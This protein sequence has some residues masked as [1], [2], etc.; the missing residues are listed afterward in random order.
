MSQSS[1]ESTVSFQT[2]QTSINADSHFEFKYKTKAEEE[3]G[4]RF[5]AFKE[6]IFNY[7]E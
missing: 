3:I 6:T 5:M 2:G 4:L 1:E 7:Y